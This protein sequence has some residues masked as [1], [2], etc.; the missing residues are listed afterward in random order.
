MIS[1]CH[2]RFD[3][4]CRWRM[5]TIEPFESNYDEEEYQRQLEER[6]RQE[7]QEAF[8]L[9]RDKE[10]EE[11]EW[12]EQQDSYAD[13]IWAF[14]EEWRERQREYAEA[15]LPELPYVDDAWCDV[16]NRDTAFCLCICQMCGNLIDECI[17]E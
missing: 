5:M 3:C 15:S 13:D 14:Q 8:E 4:R 12:R 10:R 7:I 17:C 6:E 9:L 2:I 16:C 11:E 1:I